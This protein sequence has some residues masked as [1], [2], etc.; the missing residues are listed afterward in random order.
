MI[1]ACG[2]WVPVLKY[3]QLNRHW[4]WSVL[5]LCVPCFSLRPQRRRRPRASFILGQWSVR[6]SDTNPR[7]VLIDIIA[8]FTSTQ[9]VH[10]RCFRL[11]IDIRLNSQVNMPVLIM[12]WV[13]NPWLSTSGK[14]LL[15]KL[16]DSPTP[17]D[18]RTFFELW[19]C[20]HCHQQRTRM[21]GIEVDPRGSL[22][23]HCRGSE[24]WSCSHFRAVSFSMPHGG[25]PFFLF[26]R[27]I[28]LC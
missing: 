6:W 28:T 9:M 25:T 1:W 27:F 18:S 3:F 24:P 13:K 21:L 20:K 23:F 7:F 17:G 11:K 8:R 4:I 22:L 16:R 12:F 14:T 15:F 2:I 5:L 10:L 26:I 19:V